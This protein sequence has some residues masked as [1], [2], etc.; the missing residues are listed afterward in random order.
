[1]RP[2]GSKIW[3]VD[4]SVTSISAAETGGDYE[5]STGYQ[6]GVV[7]VEDTVLT[8]IVELIVFEPCENEM[9]DDLTQWGR[10]PGRARSF[11]PRAVKRWTVSCT[12]LTSTP[13]RSSGADAAVLVP[14]IE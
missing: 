1:M 6:F 11:S 14:R 2:E 7:S 8:P 12:P 9:V 10:R 13:T 4:Y 3:Y 5:P